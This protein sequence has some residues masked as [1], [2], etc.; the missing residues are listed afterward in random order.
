MVMHFDASHHTAHRATTDDLTS[1]EESFFAILLN[2]SESKLRFYLC[3]S[4]AQFLNWHR[5]RL[6]GM[7]AGGDDYL[8]TETAP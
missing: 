1:L 7:M 3:L 6:V 8:T 2:D 4:S 5:I